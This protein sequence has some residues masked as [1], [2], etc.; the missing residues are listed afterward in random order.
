MKPKKYVREKLKEKRLIKRKQVLV[1]NWKDR[2]GS[3]QLNFQSVG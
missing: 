2:V 1:E 3:F